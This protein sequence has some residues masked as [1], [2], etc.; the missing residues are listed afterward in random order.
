M[1]SRRSGD[2]DAKQQQRRTRALVFPLRF[3]HG[4]GGRR[5]RPGQSL[6]V[7]LHRGSQRRGGLRHRL[8]RRDC[9][10]GSSHCCRRTPD[11]PPRADESR[12]QLCQPGPR[13]RRLPGLAPG[14]HAQRAGGFPDPEFL[15]R[16]RRLGLCL[17]AQAGLGPFRR[18]RFGHRQFGLHRTCWPRRGCSL[19]GMPCS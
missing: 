1:L 18:R 14:G 12:Q 7:S 4:G 6:E 9:G 13:S 8:Y 3:S 2:D 17:S 11:R 19:S 16:D 15:Q 10:R 5:R